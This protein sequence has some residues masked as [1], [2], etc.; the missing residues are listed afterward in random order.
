MTDFLRW[1]FDG[2]GTALA[3][4]AAARVR[5][6]LLSRAVSRRVRTT[7]FTAGSGP[8]MTEFYAYLAAKISSARH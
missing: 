8:Y 2:L 1:M 5:R 6:R 4:F 7:V 3:G